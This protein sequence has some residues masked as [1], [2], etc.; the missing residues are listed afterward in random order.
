M[1]RPLITARALTRGAAW[2]Q[3]GLALPLLSAILLV[4]PLIR[5]LGVDRFG[6]LSLAWLLIGYFSLFD[7]GVSGALT[8]LVAERRSLDR[9]HE[10]PALV[11]T[12][13]ALTAAM[14]TVGGVVLGGASRWLVEVGLRVPPALQPETL[15]MVR[16]LAG[17][18]PVVTCTA[19]LAGVLAAQQRFGVLTVIRAPMGVLTY[20]APL[21][22]AFWIP[23]LDAVGLALVA[24]RVAGGI[25]H[26]VACLIA[27]PGMRRITLRRD[28][29]RPI[30]SFGGWMSVSA[31]VS[32]IMVYLDRFLIG[33]MYSMAMVAYYTTP[34]DLTTR[35]TVLALPVVNVMFP[36]FAASFDLDRPRTARL[37][38]WGVR[39]TT[40]LMF[41]IALGLALFPR[42]LLGLWL[43]ADFAAHAAPVLRLLTIA[44][45]ANGLAQLPLAFLQSSGR[46]DL[47]ARLHLLEMPFYLAV[48]WALTR[49][50]GIEGAAI[51]CLCRV[52]FDALAILWLSLRRLGADAHRVRGAVVSAG[53]AFASLVAGGLLPGLGPRLIFAAVVLA[54]FGVVAWRHVARRGVQS[55]FG[56]NEG[57]SS[58]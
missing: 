2:N 56:P 5:A 10:V 25:A 6:V 21:L 34:Y 37:L 50:W 38:A 39:G 42:E 31:V 49:A 47:G 36:A 27:I 4:P 23:R 12:A 30:V 32:P 26:F 1:A 17:I 3:L 22:V 29:L 52:L 14:G 33:G 57:A 40:V 44:M 55:L 58:R 16:M 35:M 28:Q 20:A 53:V 51:A 13:L 19:A 9:D 41:P 43:G 7:L 48:L 18:L 45:F 15:I 8:R 46:P 11:W 24:V 54:A